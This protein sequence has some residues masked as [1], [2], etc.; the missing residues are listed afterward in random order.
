MNFFPFERFS[1]YI[2]LGFLVVIQRLSVYL[3]LHTEKEL[4]SKS[5]DVVVIDV[6]TIALRV[7]G[8]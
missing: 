7:Q 6:L 4:D 2:N 1:F 5:W 8:F 3:F